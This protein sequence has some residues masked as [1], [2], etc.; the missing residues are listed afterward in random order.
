MYII[1]TANKRQQLTKQLDIFTKKQCHC[2]IN[3]YTNYCT[4]NMFVTGR[5]PNQTGW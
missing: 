2:T 5:I 3:L 1:I 4:W